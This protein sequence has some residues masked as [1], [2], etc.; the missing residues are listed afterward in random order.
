V[1]VVVDASVAIKWV[2][3]ERGTAAALELRAEVLIAPSLWLAEAA[4]ALW[5]HVRLGELDVEEA[6]T[7]MRDLAAA[8]VAAFPVEPH[9]ERSL[10]LAA[11]LQHPVYDCFYL[12]LAL[13]HDTYVVTD[14]RRFV[15]AANRPDLAGRVRLL[16]T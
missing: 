15:R 4:N 13:Q 1:S 9:V 5:K 6:L 2:L 7:R 14:D 12:V 3:N 11:Q 8:P 16:G 10:E